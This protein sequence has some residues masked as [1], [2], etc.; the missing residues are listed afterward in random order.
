M[1]VDLIIIAIIALS[2]FLAYRKGLVTLAISLCAFVI[3]VVV[4]FILDKPISN[5]VINVTS[6]DETIENAIL[7]NANDV[8]KE[9][10]NSEEITDVIIEEAKNEMLPKT[11]RTLAI[12]IVTGGVILILFI[13]IRVAIRFVSAIAN[14]IAKLPI[15][16][17]INK[18]G[19]VIYGL[20]R[21][22]LIIY[23]AL[24]IINI[25]GQISP[26]NMISTNVENSS[27]GKIMYQNN[28]LNVF[29]K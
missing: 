15:L 25:A 2:T 18:L 9:E 7:E 8:M 4:T 20:I 19:G 12:N 3:A 29:F 1:I 24:F 26:D 22:L 21:G 16:D 10:S 11:A 27:L 23:I 14:L 13:L 6:I 28:I 17:Q 5:L